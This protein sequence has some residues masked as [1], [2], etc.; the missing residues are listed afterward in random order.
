MTTQQK[1]ATIQSI[2]TNHEDNLAAVR[3]AKVGAGLDAVV[4]DAM[5]TALKDDLV[6]V[7]ASK[8]KGPEDALGLG[9]PASGGLRLG[10]RVTA[11][12]S[13]ESDCPISFS[14]TR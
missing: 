5:N 1:T 7:F 10:R 3:A 8:P 4:V 14:I 13:P 11:D 9:C 2:L 12:E 6:L